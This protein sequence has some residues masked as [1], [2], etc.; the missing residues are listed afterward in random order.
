MHLR[1]G[2]TQQGGVKKMMLSWVG[3]VGFQP[4]RA[5]LCAVL[6]LCLKQRAHIPI[7]DAISVD[8]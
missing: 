7:K 6:M 4:S 5:S 8:G 3:P 2:K 1:G